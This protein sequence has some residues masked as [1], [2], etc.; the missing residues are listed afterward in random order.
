M[1][2]TERKVL[3]F[4]GIDDLV[5]LGKRTE[6]KITRDITI[7]AWV[8]ATRQRKWDG[9]VSR[10]FDTNASESGYCLML[11]GAGGIQA[12][13]RTIG[14]PAEKF[15]YSSGE[16]TLPLNE[17]HHIAATYDG[18][19]VIVYVDG[20]LK[21]KVAQ[22]GDI[23]YDPDHP[24]TIATFRDDDESQ[25]FAGKIAE[26]RIWNVARTEEQI[27]EAMHQALRGSEEGL[28]GYWPMDEGSGSIIK[29]R[30]KNGIHGTISGASW[31]DASV[32]FGKVPE[33]KTPSISNDLEKRLADLEEKVGKC[34]SCEEKIVALEKRITEL[35]AKF[36]RLDDKTTQCDGCKEALADQKKIIEGL[37]ERISQLEAQ[38]APDKTPEAT[39]DKNPEP[40]KWPPPSTPA[41][42]VISYIH[43][44]GSEKGSQGDEY[45]EIKNTGGTAQDIS[46]WRVHAGSTGQ[47]FVFAQGSVLLPG[48]VARIYTN[49]DPNKAGSY[50]FKSKKAL[51]NDAGDLGQLF[52]ASGKSVSE[53]GY[54]TKETRSI[55]D[56]KATYGVEKM[57]L[58]YENAQIAKQKRKNDKVDFL[59]AVERAVRSLL[60]DPADQDTPNAANQMRDN[61]EGVPTDASAELL[62]RYIRDH[63]N[64]NQLRLLSEDSWEK[65][66]L[67]VST[68]DHWVFLLDKGLGD[69]HWVVVERMGAKAAYQSIT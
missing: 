42:V 46:G 56:I 15:Y 4:D 45:L 12:G 43:F 21:K 63:M 6:H 16:K 66:E 47:D 14:G 33:V 35:E 23:D 10:T 55:D 28:V 67:G 64:Q 13:L 40:T 25:Y 49:I 5:D 69:F 30:S 31:Q 2:S 62:E 53:Y 18:K 41:H 17:W 68:K 19:H 20:E 50:S 3:S 24:L 58:V 48:A 9:I 34:G 44:V 51:W 52:N 54:G 59:T 29:D 38:K 32:S 61:V 11:D 36:S 57:A 65:S 8:Y 60:Q 22:T 1:V 39:P 37:V 27:K 7:E 26:V